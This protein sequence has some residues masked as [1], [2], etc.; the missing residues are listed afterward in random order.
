MKTDYI[1]GYLY[2]KII[3]AVSKPIVVIAAPQ[4]SAP[5]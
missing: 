5:Y 2:I 3:L 1:V 4:Y